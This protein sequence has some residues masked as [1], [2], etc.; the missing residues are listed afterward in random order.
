MK[1]TVYDSRYF[2]K[3]HYWDFKPS[4][5]A[6]RVLELAPPLNREL[7]LLD[8]GCGEGGNAIFFAKNGYKVSGFDLSSVGVQKTKEI[9]EKHQVEID[10][11]LADINDFEIRENFDIIF[12]SGTLQYLLPDKRKSLI[13]SLQ[14]HT[15]DN[16]LHVL[17]T[18]VKKPFVE[19]APDA[20]PQ[21]N[22]WDSGELLYYYRDWKTESFVEEIKPCNSSGVPH[23]HVH[24]RIWSRKPGTN[25]SLDNT[26][27]PS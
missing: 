6:Y 27:R 3:Q 14:R 17:H 4:T 26:A 9:A 15:N 2:S 13:T 11:F 5:M 7:R 20:E 22:L 10:L 12:S 18:F 24:N 19:M 16:G 21:E 1:N 8:I 23:Q 25:T